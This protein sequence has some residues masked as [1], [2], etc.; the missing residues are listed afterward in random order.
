MVAVVERPGDAR[1]DGEERAVDGQQ[2]A[3]QHLK[4]RVVRLD[5]DPLAEIVHQRQ[6]ERRV[7]HLLR[8]RKGALGQLGHAQPLAHRGDAEQVFKAPEP[9]E[10]G[11]EE[12]QEVGDHQMVQL[13]L[14]VPMGRGGVQ[15][16]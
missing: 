2:A 15:A 10:G 5:P 13:D 16:I 7:E 4:T 6:Q 8:I 11:V 1:S 14:P 12:R 9:A 3:S